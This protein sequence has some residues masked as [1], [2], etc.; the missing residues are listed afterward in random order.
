MR[1]KHTIY[2]MWVKVVALTHMNMRYER[3]IMIPS[4][5]SAHPYSPTN[6]LIKDTQK[7]FEILLKKIYI[8]KKIEKKE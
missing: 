6:D 2:T 3:E 8:V 7:L 1:E 5:L 4:D